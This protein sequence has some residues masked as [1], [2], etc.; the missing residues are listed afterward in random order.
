MSP[1]RAS[2]AEKAAGDKETSLGLRFAGERYRERIPRE[3]KKE[4]GATGTNLTKEALSRYD[5]VVA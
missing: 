3:R 4:R 5:P 1:Q 2:R